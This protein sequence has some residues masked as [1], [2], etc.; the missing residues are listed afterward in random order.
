[1]DVYLPL[2]SVERKWKDRIKRLSLPLFPSY[3]FLHAPPLCRSEVLS[4][5]GVYQFVEFGGVPCAI[6]P[7]EIEALRR[8]V[9][10]RLAVEPHPFLKCGDRVRVMSG[11]LSGV[12][13]ILVRYKASSRLVVSIEILN[14]S[15]SVEVSSID[16]ERSLRFSRP[17]Y[18]PC[19]FSNGTTS[20]THEQQKH[21]GL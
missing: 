14:R 6:P 2:Y 18:L 10:S 3:I 8:T 12:E 15:V 5:S 11:P 17:S 9:S 4:L 20:L 19:D 7:H 1:M 21:G 13:G 16:V